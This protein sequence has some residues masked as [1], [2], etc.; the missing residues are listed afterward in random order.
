M[1]VE[2][3]AMASNV[4]NSFVPFY[5]NID[6][7]PDYLANTAGTVTTDNFYWANRLIGALADAHY[8]QCKAHIERYQNKV[9]NLGHAL[10]ARCDRELP[11]NGDIPAYL[12]RCNEEIC[13]AAR[14]LTDVVLGQVLYEASLKMQNAYS[15][16]DA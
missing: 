15:R 2:W 11:E 1:A 4:F 6:R 10:I 14:E 16:E 3:V 13:A 12:E 9:A 8:P 5:A 7:T